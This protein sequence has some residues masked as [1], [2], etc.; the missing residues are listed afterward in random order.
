M[1]NP[2]PQPRRFAALLVG[3]TVCVALVGYLLSQLY[4]FSNPMMLAH[5]QPKDFFELYLGPLLVY[6]VSLG[7]IIVLSKLAS[8]AACVAL[9]GLA[10]TFSALLLAAH[11]LVLFADG[12]FW[13]L[14]YPHSGVLWVTV[15]LWL[16]PLTAWGCVLLRHRKNSASPSWPRRKVV[17]AAAVI[18]A[19]AALAFLLFLRF[20]FAP[21]QARVIR[22]FTKNR[23]AFVLAADALV[24]A[25]GAEEE[26][27]HVRRPRRFLL[28]YT[29]ASHWEGTHA[30]ITEND[31]LCTALKTLGRMGYTE[32]YSVCGAVWFCLRDDL[33]ERGVYFARKQ[34]IVLYAEEAT[35]RVPM[36]GFTQDACV[37]IE[38]GVSYWH[39][40]GLYGTPRG[41]DT[42]E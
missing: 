27:V 35:E 5:E 37:P 22:D 40:Y 13:Y 15:P 7:A 3:G 14:Y 8:R 2:N 11:L 9:R 16:S 25:V 20:G 33:P 31:S 1:G 36:K 38:D 17:L 18:A 28:G 26:I 30:V 10:W 24:E 34:G 23:E 39:A 19:T 4:F 41:D 32:I 21:S 6:L 29:P 12:N 42:Q